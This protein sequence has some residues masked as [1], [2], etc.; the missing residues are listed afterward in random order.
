M[1]QKYYDEII[2]DLVE[3]EV[4]KRFMRISQYIF[5]VEL[6]FFLNFEILEIDND[7]DGSLDGRIDQGIFIL[8][9]VVGI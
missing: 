7:L 5:V 6:F 1:V 3:V 4:K 8:I 9:E 2:R